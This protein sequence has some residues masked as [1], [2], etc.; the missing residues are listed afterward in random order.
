MLGFA[1]CALILSSCSQNEELVDNSKLNQEEIK[2]APYV[3]KTK[4]SVTNLDAMKNNTDGFRV[5][6]VQHANVQT[7]GQS[8]YQGLPVF[9]NSLK[10]A[11][12]DPNDLVNGIWSYG[13]SKYYWP[14]TDALSFFAIA[15]DNKDKVGK[16]NQGSS[17]TVPITIQDD[18]ASQIDILAASALNLTRETNTNG[19]VDFQFEH[20]L[21]RI[22]F[23][24]RLKE[25]ENLKFKLNEIKYAYGSV[26]KTGRFEY[27]NG[28]FVDDQQTMHSNPDNQILKLTWTAAGR[29]NI[30]ESTQPKYIHD[31]DSYFMIIPQDLSKGN[32]VTLTIKYQIAVA[33]DVWGKVREVSV[34]IPGMK[35]VMGSA[36]THNLIFSGDTTGNDD[37]LEVKFGVTDVQSWGLE[38]PDQGTEVPNS[39]PSN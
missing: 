10:V 3:N 14:E 37:L 23:K 24:A 33:G 13:D 12:S 28:T 11:W 7:E 31:L 9:M 18:V 8:G 30:I 27:G 6:A 17:I 29:E 38:V 4:A 39:K 19:K 2:F 22:G 20:I 16:F 36:Y 32:F 35:Y 5:F 1:A 26:A 25:G 15:P 21:S 34:T